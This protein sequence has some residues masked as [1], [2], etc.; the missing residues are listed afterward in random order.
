MLRWAKLLPAWANL[1]RWPDLL[2]ARQLHQQRDL[3]YRG[4][5]GLWERL[6][7]IELH[8]LLRRPG[9]SPTGRFLLTGVR[10]AHEALTSVAGNESSVK[11]GLAQR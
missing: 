7:P 2:R 4:I 11:P 5:P 3:L 8:L 1:L 10:A 9:V 6:L